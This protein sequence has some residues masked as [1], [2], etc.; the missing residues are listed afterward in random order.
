LKKENYLSNYRLKRKGIKIIEYEIK[1]IF[2]SA[3]KIIDL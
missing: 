2:G 3:S 1:M